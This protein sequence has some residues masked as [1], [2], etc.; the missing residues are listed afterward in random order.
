MFFKS[1]DKFFQIENKLIYFSI[2]VMSSDNKE[3]KFDL[4]ESLAIAQTDDQNIDTF[5][6]N[7]INF[8][9]EKQINSLKTN[10]SLKGL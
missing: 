4:N 5:N 7:L 1:I 3:N 10:D 6:T 9:E 2:K 8:N